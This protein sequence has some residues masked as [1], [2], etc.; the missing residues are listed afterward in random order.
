MQDRDERL[1]VEDLETYDST[2]YGSVSCEEE[3]VAI[4][5]QATEQG[6]T[7]DILMALLKDLA[8][9]EQQYSMSLDELHRRFAQDDEDLPPD[10]LLWSAI[11]YRFIALSSLLGARP[12]AR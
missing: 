3:F 4:L 7:V 9:Y 5:T 10:F 12:C 1:A 6:S 2:A 8:G 11:Y